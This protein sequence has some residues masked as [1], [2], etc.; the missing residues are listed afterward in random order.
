MTAALIGLAF[1]CLLLLV[2]ALPVEITLSIAC[3]DACKSEMLV[4]LLFGLVKIPIRRISP[5]PREETEQ[6]FLRVQSNKAFSRELLAELRMFF[7]TIELSL[8][9]LRLRF[10]FDDPALTGTAYGNLCALRT[11][12]DQFHPF[13]ITIQPYFDGPVFEC[14]GKARIR[15]F[16]L[17]SL[18][19]MIRSKHL[20]T[21][22]S[23]RNN[24]VSR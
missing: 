21:M 20:R 18:F 23:R 16:P 2:L 9:H 14:E 12:M 5:M 6:L 15:L 10:G 13:D 19:V 24:R 22:A 7:K 4:I 8:L 3:I 11:A 17:Q 1:L